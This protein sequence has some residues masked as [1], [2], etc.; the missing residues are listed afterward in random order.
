M[1]RE[2]LVI[3]DI[4]VGA[5]DISRLY[6]EY[7]NMF[8]DYI[9]RLDKLDFVII[10]GDFFDHKFYLNDKKSVMA[11]KMLTDLFEVCKP[12]NTK[13]RIVY[14]TESHECNQYDVLSILDNY[15]DIRIIKQCEEE[16]LFEDMKVLYIPEERLE[17]PDK[18]YEE[19]FIKKEYYDYIF[20]HGIIREVMTDAVVAM[21]NRKSF[22]SSKQLKV[23][24][25]SS[26]QLEYCCKGQTFFGHYHINKNINDKVF[27]CGSFSRWIF[28]EE[29]DKG[30]YHIAR[31]CKNK[32][33]SKFIKNQQA[34]TFVTIGYGYESDIYSDIDKMDQALNHADNLIKDK[35]FDHVRF[36][37]SIPASVENPESTV[38]Y[39]KERYK[40]DDKVKLQ[41]VHGYIENR[42]EEKKKEIER[43]NAVF[44]FIY[45][46]NVA[47]DEKVQRFIYIK[48]GR[49]ILRD[50]IKVY[51]SNPVQEIINNEMIYNITNESEDN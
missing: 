44:V 18:Y 3:S 8:I 47:I 49:D 11:Y 41:I 35:V 42:K 16:D 50:Y 30:F 31:S 32:Y 29:E 39:L 22:K 37:F 51:L 5:F 25:F 23:P 33:A 40:F 6:T 28:G 4:H 12:K 38:N 19:Y 2:G 14:G 43:D 15:D 7:T 45:D 9:R 10:A 20:G 17:N 26:A 1:K 27:Y 34:Q 13:I 46:K 21:E 36:M 48:N 24:I